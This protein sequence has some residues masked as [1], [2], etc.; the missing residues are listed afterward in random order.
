MLWVS[1]PVTGPVLVRFLAAVEKVLKLAF[2]VVNIKTPAPQVS[3]KL[4]GSV[5]VI[6]VIEYMVRWVVQEESVIAGLKKSG[7]IVV[8]TAMVPGV[9]TVLGMRY[10][11]Q[12]LF[13]TEVVQKV[14][15]I[16]IGTSKLTMMLKSVGRAAGLITIAA[17]EI[18]DRESITT[19]D[20]QKV[21][22]T[23]ITYGRIGNIAIMGVLIH[24]ANQ[25]E[26][27]VGTG[28]IQKL[29][30]IPIPGVFVMLIDLRPLTTLN[31]QELLLMI[32]L[33]AVLL[34]S[35]RL[36]PLPPLT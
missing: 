13:T 18:G 34:T 26:L 25:E 11:D 5:Q 20:V 24:S 12:E 21:L 7:N 1:S 36:F 32:V 27:T 6:G 23:K 16:L 28:A 4:T 10:I 2:L 8:L 33:A 22:V 29:A 31:M 9:T 19:K 17:Q 15:V 30:I 3:G 14:P 35:L